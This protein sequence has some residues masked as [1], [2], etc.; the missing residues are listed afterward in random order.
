MN[1]TAIIRLIR[2][3]EL[4][5]LLELYRQLHTEDS[6]I[7]PSE[8]LNHQW[9]EMF[10]NPKMKF[11]VTEDGGKLAAVSGIS[12]LPTGSLVIEQTKF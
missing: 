5:G 4:D 9:N 6:V 3:D 8:D 2:H 10:H 7:P 12:A 11:V 1:E